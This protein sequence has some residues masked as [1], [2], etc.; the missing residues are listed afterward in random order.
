[1]GALEPVTAIVLGAW[2]FGEMLT[3]RLSVGIVLILLA[4][5]LIILDDRFRHALSGIKI[6]KR[7][8]LIVK[9]MRWK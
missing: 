5:M 2:I 7:G 3:L 1:M 8:R 6:V 4:V 9:R